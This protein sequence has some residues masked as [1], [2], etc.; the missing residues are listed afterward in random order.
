MKNLAKMGAGV[1][2]VM[3]VIGLAMPAMAMEKSSK[4]RANE[5]KQVK[6]STV[7]AYDSTKVACVGAAASK[8]EDAIDTAFSAFSTSE[9]AALS[10][11]KSD[12]A[13]AYADSTDNASLKTAV[14]SAWKAFRD[15]KAAARMAFWNVR[16]EAWKTFK[17]E[18]KTCGGT[19]V[20]NA[21]MSNEIS[22]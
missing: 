6:T 8:R 22:K 4:D 11:R 16:T 14:K 12:L 17:A 15:S 13:R 1:V 19:S 18:V 5:F 2:G 20:E 7:Q 3:T 10:S 9:M 21:D